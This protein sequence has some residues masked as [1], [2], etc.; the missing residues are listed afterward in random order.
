M[1]GGFTGGKIGGLRAWHRI[2]AGLLEK[3]DV[4]HMV[5]A[6]VGRLKS[7]PESELVR[8]YIER[9]ATHGRQCGI[10]GVTVREIAESRARRATDRRAEEAKEIGRAHV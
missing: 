10:S 3:D 8:L 5:I 6:A 4:M 9:A 1:V 7:G 2:S